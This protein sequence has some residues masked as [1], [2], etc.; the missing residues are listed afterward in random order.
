[1]TEHPSTTRAVEY[2]PLDDV[3][4]ADRNPKRHD[5][6]TLARSV[7]RFG[8]VEPMVRDERTGRLVA[9]HGRLDELRMARARHP[10]TAPDGVVID[11]QG[12]WLVPVVV[13]WGSASDSEAEAYLVASNRTV[14]SGGWDETILTDLL[15]DLEPLGADAFDGMGFTLDDALAMISKRMGD[16]ADGDDGDARPQLEGLRYRVVI[17]ADDE[18]H[19][20]E[21]IDELTGRGLSVRAVVN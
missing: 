16:E 3:R 4:P 8:F 7:R 10:G 17:D 20:A 21:L 18:A 5:H 11:E 12:R 19:Q 6:A 1:M 14:E 2:V 15:A 9:G 13:G